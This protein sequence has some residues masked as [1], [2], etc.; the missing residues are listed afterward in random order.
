[1]RKITGA[2]SPY[3]TSGRCIKFEFRF[4]HEINDMVVPLPIRDFPTL[5]E[6]EKVVEKLKNNGKL[7]GHRWVDRLGVST[8]MKRRKSHISSLNPRGLETLIST[9][10]T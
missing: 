10:N 7:K 8:D 6:N 5:I 4:K 9:N 3:C 2:K 1:M